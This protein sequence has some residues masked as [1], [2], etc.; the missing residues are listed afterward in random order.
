M[1]LTLAGS[2]LFGSLTLE[3]LKRF[4]GKAG[5]PEKLTTDT[6]A[7][8]VEAFRKAWKDS[9]DLAIDDF[10][11]DRMDAHLGKIPIWKM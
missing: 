9:G 6:A 7:T 8:T 4:A 11:R 10:V 5:L 1:A 2:K 3:Q